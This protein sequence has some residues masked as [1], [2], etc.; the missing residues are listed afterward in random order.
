[1]TL[2]PARRDPHGTG[3]PPTAA[4][5]R[6]CDVF[7]ACAVCNICSP[8]SNSPNSSSASM[9][10]PLPDCRATTRPACDADQPPSDSRSTPRTMSCLPRRPAA[11]RK[12]QRGRRSPGRWSRRLRAMPETSAQSSSRS[13]SSCAPA[14]PTGRNLIQLRRGRPPGPTQPTPRPS[15]RYSRDTV[16]EITRRRLG[17]IQNSLQKIPQRLQTSTVA[18]EVVLLSCSGSFRSS[19]LI[20]MPPR[21]SP[22]PWSGGSPHPCVYPS[23]PELAPMVPSG[24]LLRARLHL[25]CAGRSPS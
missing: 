23:A 11:H 8:S 16:G 24:W 12:P 1:M 19:R 7:T 17:V 14:A 6:R 4:G 15:C 21:G 5:T 9:I 25:L 20:P 18:C 13:L 2:A 10:W 22:K 3:S